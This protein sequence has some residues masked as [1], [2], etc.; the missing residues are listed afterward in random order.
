M[1]REKKQEGGWREERRV[2]EQDR[3]MEIGTKK[4]RKKIEYLKDTIVCGYLI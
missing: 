1:K 3:K 2:A 4:K